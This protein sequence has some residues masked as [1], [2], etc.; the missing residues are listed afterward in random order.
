MNIWVEYWKIKNTYDKNY[1]AQSRPV[2]WEEP[3]KEDI[4]KRF[5]Q[6]REDASKFAQSMQ[7]SGHHTR[8]KEDK[9]K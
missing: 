6:S 3:N 8:I 1:Y 2:K 9:S 4:H 7:N 5:C